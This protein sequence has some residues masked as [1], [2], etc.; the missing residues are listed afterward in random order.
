M[1]DSEETVD[2][3]GYIIGGADIGEFAEYKADH[4]NC[5]FNV[6]DG[7]DANIMA[8]NLSTA[9]INS[10]IELATA[11]TDASAD[12]LIVKYNTNHL[13]IYR[14]LR[15]VTSTLAEAGCSGTDASVL[16]LTT[17][18]GATVAQGRADVAAVQHAAVLLKGTEAAATG[19]RQK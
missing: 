13:T 15:G 14:T 7:D 19:R 18:D 9:A 6:V 17:D 10:W 5:V 3:G 4:E 16:K 8:V 12:A 11:I 1:S 2:E